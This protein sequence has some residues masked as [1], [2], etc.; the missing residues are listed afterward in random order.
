MFRHK[1]AHKWFGFSKS[2]ILFV[3]ILSL[4]TLT[5]TSV[6]IIFLRPT[7]PASLNGSCEE[8][9]YCSFCMRISNLG[10]VIADE[11]CVC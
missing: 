3:K 11:Q 1:L 9:S 5:A 8:H 6:Q 4:S 2:P 10:P 7:N